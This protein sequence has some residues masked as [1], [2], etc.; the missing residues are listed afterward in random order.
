MFT[1]WYLLYVEQYVGKSYFMCNNFWPDVAK[2]S[3]CQNSEHWNLTHHPTSFRDDPEKTRLR[4]VLEKSDQVS[5]LWF[6]HWPFSD[7]L[8][9]TLNT[10]E[11]SYEEVLHICLER[12][13]EETFDMETFCGEKAICVL[14]ALWKDWTGWNFDRPTLCLEI[15]NSTWLIWQRLPR[16]IKEEFPLQHFNNASAASLRWK[17]PRWNNDLVQTSQ[18]WQRRSDMIDM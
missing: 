18:K 1:I 5:T 7:H 14:K 3:L 2:L 15:C 13:S 16:R 10:E 8:Q 17:G 9:L 11:L 4:S 6:H 12:F